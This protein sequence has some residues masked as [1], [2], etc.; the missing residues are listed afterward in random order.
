MVSW[1]R[2][3]PW[4]AIA[5]AGIVLVVFG[6]DTAPRMAA[7]DIPALA[8]ENSI[9]AAAAPE[10][11]GQAVWVRGVVDHVFVSEDENYFINFCPDF[12]NCVFS[13]VIFAEE[14]AQFADVE[15]W[16]GNHIHVYGTLSTYEGRPQIIIEHPAQVQVG[17][18]A[19][20]TAISNTENA[21]EVLAVVDGDTI[22]VRTGAGFEFVRLIGIDTPE[23][24]GPY[25]EEECFGPEASRRAAELLEGE[26]VVLVA[27]PRTAERDK[28]DRLLRH[29]FTE[30]GR[31][32]NALLVEEGFARYFPF[33]SFSYM[34]DFAELEARAKADRLGL[35][36]ACG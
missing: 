13:A 4:L 21:V 19:E 14:A 28:Y 5:V 25:T 35:W 22:W 8:T 29:V 17:V 7:P 1:E 12:R 24:A 3:W 9:D 11:I 33:E 31:H 30:D 16:R 27:D 23:V 26:R 20:E 34:D 18:R 32:V 2:V 10:H 15:E 36:G 6:F